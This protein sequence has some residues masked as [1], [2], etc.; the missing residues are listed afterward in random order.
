MIDFRFHVLSLVA[1]FLALGLG[2]VIGVAMEGDEALLRE[3]QVIVDRLE[4]D[5]NALREQNRLFQQEIDLIKN[6]NEHYQEFAQEVL[7]LLVENKLAGKN[8]AIVVTDGYATTEGLESVLSLAGAQLV[9][10]ARI[11]GGFNFDDGETQKYICEK[12]GFQEFPTKAQY[13]N[14]LAYVIT[15]ALQGRLNPGDLDFLKEINLATFQVY[16]QQPIDIVVLLGGSREKLGEPENII[17]LPIID[18]LL[19]K[20]ISVAGTETS[21]VE[22]SYMGLYQSKRIATIDNIDTPPG[23]VALIWAL[24]KAPGN[25]GIKTTADDFLPPLQP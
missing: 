20:G 4:E 12:L 23:Q 5:F 1:I 10:I 19:Q 21:D 24:A 18:C 11:N 17:D 8:V 25:Y 14:Q 7:P 9:S 22:T 13:M 2:I 16:S 6:L 3:Q 15:E